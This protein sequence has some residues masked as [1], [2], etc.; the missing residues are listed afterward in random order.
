M[1]E[2]KLSASVD[3]LLIIVTDH[4]YPV[5]DQGCQIMLKYAHTKNCIIYMTYT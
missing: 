4:N 3:I 2:I 1:V 5:K